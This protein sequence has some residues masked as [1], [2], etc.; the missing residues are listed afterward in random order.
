MKNLLVAVELEPSDSWLLY[1]ATLLAEKFGSKIWLVHIAEP[2]PDFIGY[3]IGPAYI[4]DFRAEELKA[5][6]K[7]LHAYIEDLRKKSLDAEGLLIQGI[8]ADMIEA[9]VTKLHIDLLILGSH[10]HSFLYE[11]F[12]GHTANKILKDITIPVLIVPLPYES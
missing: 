5:E 8:T 10:H 9:E 7:Q 12:V 6:H 1:Q 11:A 3:G 4:R 2:D